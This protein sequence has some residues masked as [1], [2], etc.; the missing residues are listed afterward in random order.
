MH[1][2]M[3]RR[4]EA[5]AGRLAG[6]RRDFHMHPELSFTEVRTSTIAGDHLESLGLTVR[7]GVGR[8][9]L[10]AERGEGEICVGVR[11][12]M[13]ALPIREA[14]RVEYASQNEGIMHACGHDAHTAMAMGAAELLATLELPGRVRFLFQPSEEAADEEGYSG[15]PRMVQDGAMEGVDSVI[16]L[17]VHSSASVGNI[18]VAAGPVSAGV[19]SF[20][21]RIGGQSA[22]GAYPHRGVD[23]VH[24]ASFVVQ[25]L[26]GIVARRINPFDPAVVTVG[27]ICGGT[28]DNVIAKEVVLSGTIR[29]LDDEVHSTIRR[30]LERAAKVAEAF[31]CTS[32]LEIVEGS[33][34]IQ[35]DPAVVAAIA[36]AAT[37]LLGPDS[38]KPREEGMG[39]EDFACFTDLA[40]GAMFRLG[41]RIEDDERKA[42]SPTFDID[43][44]CLPIGAALLAETAIRLL[45]TASSAPDQ[46]S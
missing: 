45:R 46:S 44:R 4:A 21:I 29:Y 39:A 22:H 17:H 5:M 20:R 11:A 23:P 18:Q 25:A 2:N 19:D 26:H 40:P 14:N 33:G 41:C 12:D 6:W 16:A 37:D 28:A 9:G 1:S 36:E 42:H 34:P 30:G 27:S 35:N 13:D 43:E 10:V 15:A 7:R 32:T 38:V 3:L 24:A 31:C 8:T